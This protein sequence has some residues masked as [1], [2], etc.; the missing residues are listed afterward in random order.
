MSKRIIGTILAAIFATATLG[1]ATAFADPV[2]PPAQCT[3]EAG[4][5]TGEDY[6]WTQPNR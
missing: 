1:T 5:C 4:E 2:D 3:P 6:G